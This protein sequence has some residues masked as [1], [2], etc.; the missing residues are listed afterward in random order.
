MRGAALWALVAVFL[1][2]GSVAQAAR[3]HR[4]KKPSER[5]TKVERAKAKKHHKADES[6]APA[7]PLLHA[8]V[9][10]ADCWAEPDLRPEATALSILL[11][12]LV[13]KNLQV[14]WS[15][16]VATATAPA[17]AA[18]L[19]DGRPALYL[20]SRQAKTI[21]PRLN[22]DYLVTWNCSTD[23]VNFVATVHL[24]DSAG[25]TIDRATFTGLRTDLPAMGRAIARRL[26]RVLAVGPD[27]TRTASFGALRP[28]VRAE[29]GLLRHDVQAAALGLLGVDPTIAQELPAAANMARAVWSDPS[30]PYVERLT[31]ALATATPEEILLL[32]DALEQKEGRQAQITAARAQAYIA[33]GKLPEAGK[34]LEGF[35]ETNDPI[36]LLAIAELAE[37]QGKKEVRDAALDKL[38]G[39]RNLPALRW[40]ST[41]PSAYLPQPAE[42]AVLAAGVAIEERD[43]ALATAIGLRAARGSKTTQGLE[44]VDTNLLAQGGEVKLA[45]LLMIVAETP[46]T[47]RLRAELRLHN[48]DYDG[49][50]KDALAARAL[51]RSKTP[52]LELA[53]LLGRIYNLQGKLDLA[54]EQLAL[55][56]KVSIAAGYELARVQRMQKDPKGA[57]KTYAALGSDPTSAEQYIY[58]GADVLEGH[59]DNSEYAQLRRILRLKEMAEDA[60]QDG[61]LLKAMAIAFRITGDVDKAHEMDKAQAELLGDLEDVDEEALALGDPS[62]KV[63]TKKQVTKAKTLAPVV[64]KK[65]E[66]ATSWLWIILVVVGVGVVVGGILLLIPFVM[67]GGEV[68]LKLELD[69]LTS[70][71]IYCARLTKARDAPEIKDPAGW[72]QK[73]VA[74]GV[75]ITSRS[76]TLI[77]ETTSFDAWPGTWNLQVWGVHQKDGELQVMVP[78]IKQVKI[79]RGWNTVTEID[80][81][82]KLV[83]CQ[84]TV[85]ASG[86]PVHDA[87]VWADE[88]KARVSSAADGKANLELA[89]GSR[90]IHVEVAG[91][92]VDRPVV[93]GTIPIEVTVRVDS[94][95]AMAMN[96]PSA[97]R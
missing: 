16:M 64:G 75:R 47:L 9:A 4:K 41:L 88:A 52:N 78:V 80:L 97:T 57:A 48:K 3:G 30:R 77:N 24:N 67:G 44:L 35:A 71:R 49:A 11:R 6:K 94:A 29:R 83:P 21:L 93:V 65:Q 31:V 28:F 12:S 74:R 38:V 39:A 37:K 60:P 10:V 50:L 56:S 76:Q 5:A 22:A 33:Q 87:K 27:L 46:I 51:T 89:E 91:R 82:P 26:D 14:E 20:D 17:K 79:N 61:D 63:E 85:M 96:R 15:A 66:E 8:R 2:V 13:G 62:D 34:E 23:G 73:T 53:L 69:P 81:R 55:A 32:C 68:Q 40:I 59:S 95:T 84:V 19:P 72:S 86:G 25:M 70:K 1:T 54:A 43:A 45:A 42:Q 58:G 90:M 92:I 18:P 7:V 36:A